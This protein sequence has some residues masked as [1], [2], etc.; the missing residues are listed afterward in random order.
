MASQEVKAEMK[1]TCTGCSGCTKKIR[2]VE[3]FSQYNYQVLTKIGPTGE[4]G[5]RTFYSDLCNITKNSLKHKF[6]RVS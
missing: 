4:E 2:Y 1:V 5:S 3:I 6:C